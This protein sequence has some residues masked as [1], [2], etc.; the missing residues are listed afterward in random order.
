LKDSDVRVVI[1]MDDIDRLDKDEIQA[2]LKLVKLTG[3]FSNTAYILAFDEQMVAQ[4]LAEKYGSLEAGRNFLEKI[5]QVPLN[6]PLAHSKALVNLAFDGMNAALSLA[7]IELSEQ[8]TRSTGP[9]FI[10]AFQ[11]RLDT[12]R[13]VK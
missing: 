11:D 6:L 10:E 7:H 1:V 8:E 13:L 2:V 12:P 5:V 4:A 9:F 3:D